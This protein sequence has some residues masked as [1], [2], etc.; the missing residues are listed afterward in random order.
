[1]KDTCGAVADIINE[2]QDRAQK[3]KDAKH[4]IAY[5]SVSY[6]LILY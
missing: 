2:I 3:K 1:M 4:R 6:Q 5:I